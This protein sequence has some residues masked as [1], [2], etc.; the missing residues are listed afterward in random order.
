MRKERPCKIG[1]WSFGEHRPKPNQCSHVIR[2]LRAGIMDK[3]LLLCHI[4]VFSVNQLWI[5]TGWENPLLKL[6]IC[7]FNC[8][9]NLRGQTNELEY[10]Q[11]QNS[12]VDV[13]ERWELE[14]ER[15]RC[16]A[17]VVGEHESVAGKHVQEGKP[18]TMA[19]TC[20]RELRSTWLPWINPNVAT[21]YLQVLFQLLA[22]F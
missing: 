15:E 12:Q 17:G 18:M 11:E 6:Y 2:T 21:K 5:K 9:L 19:G 22:K 8:H 20:R 10:P 1:T 14:K 13:P 4:Y 3:H 7:G 16:G